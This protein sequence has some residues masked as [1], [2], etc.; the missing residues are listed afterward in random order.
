MS[1]AAWFGGLALL[2]LPP[3]LHAAP[4][5]VDLAW[6][7]C[8]PEGGT[9]LHYF[10]C[11]RNT[12]PYQP[13]GTMV[14]SFAPATDHPYFIGIEAVIDLLADAATLPDWWQMFNTGSCRPTGLATSMDFTAA[15]QES[16]T[17]AWVGLGQG[18]IAAYKT[19]AFPGGAPEVFTPNAGRI[20]LAFGV[21]DPVPIT[22]DTHYY[23]FKLMINAMKTVGTG[24]CAGCEVPVCLALT[25][26]R[27]YDNAGPNYEALTLP[28][29]NQVIGWQCGQGTVSHHD[30]P[31]PYDDTTTLDACSLGATPCVTPVRNRTWGSLKALYR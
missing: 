11:D 12:Y 22:A 15:P 24:A 21:Q 28:I 18:G 10:A 13:V 7:N 29:H 17:D 9:A 19:V 6:D 26:V 5:G 16:C 31:F 30:N 27:V 4:A 2:I 20:R 23:G 8:L 3:L 14:A 25:E 1:R